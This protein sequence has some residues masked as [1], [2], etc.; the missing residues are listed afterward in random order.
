M[1][2]GGS[3]V[4]DGASTQRSVLDWPSCLNGKVG[5]A[6]TVACS[7]NLL[8]SWRSTTAVGIDETP[9][10]TISKLYMGIAMTRKA[11]NTVTTFRCVYVT[12]YQDTEARR[13]A[14]VCAMSRTRGNCHRRWPEFKATDS[15][16]R[17]EE[18]RVG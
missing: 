14:K 9:T 6:P 13:D 4:N 7:S 8:T 2:S 5:A 15:E 10:L 1:G 16:A 18:R 11:G 17:S 12:T 3:G